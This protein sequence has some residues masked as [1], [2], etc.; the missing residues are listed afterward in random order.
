MM[1]SLPVPHITSSQSTICEIKFPDRKVKK[2][3]NCESPARIVKGDR[4]AIGP[5][6]QK[7]TF[8]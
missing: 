2:Y 3:P 5:H 4:F 6:F 7:N 8:V 1:L